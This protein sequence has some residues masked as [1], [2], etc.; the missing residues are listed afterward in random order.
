MSNS[1]SYPIWNKSLAIFT[2]NPFAH[3]YSNLETEERVN[4]LF[5]INYIKSAKNIIWIRLGTHLDG[6]ND[7]KLFTEYIH[8]LKY[9]VTL[10]TTDGDTSVPDEIPN[11]IVTTLLNSPMIINW[12]TQNLS[13]TDTKIRPYPIGFDLHTHYGDYI[14]HYREWDSLLKIKNKAPLKRKKQIYCDF[15]HSMYE[16]HDRSR[17]EAYKLLKKMKYTI[18][19]KDRLPRNKLWKQYTESQFVASP[20]GDGL[21]CY[22][23]W[24]ALALGAIPIVKRSTLDQLYIDNNLPVVIVDSWEECLLPKNLELWWNKYSPL[25]SS[26]MD[27]LETSYWFPDTE[28]SNSLGSKNP[29]SI[30]SFPNPI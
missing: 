25:L 19:P 14:N 1:N 28:D 16:R 17:E 3:Y 24:E 29:C 12:Y 20:H 26:V 27:K 11:D 13:S 15:Y 30:K 9:P 23:T 10:I 21:D 22:R 18:F 2:K 4:L 7:L 8:Y 6:E 5:M